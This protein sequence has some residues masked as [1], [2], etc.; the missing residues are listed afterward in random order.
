MTYGLVQIKIYSKHLFRA[1]ERLKKSSPK[2]LQNILFNIEPPSP[3][4]QLKHDDFI[5]FNKNLDESQIDA[6]KFALCQ[7]EIGIIHGPP[8]TGKTTTIVEILQQEVKLGHK[9]SKS[10]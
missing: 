5:L 7:P 9:V 2:R 8:G 10:N 3:P 1:I 4:V 6:V